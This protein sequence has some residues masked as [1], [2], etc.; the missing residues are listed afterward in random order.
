[1][2]CHQEPLF[3]LIDTLSI[4]GLHRTGHLAVLESEGVDLLWSPEFIGLNKIF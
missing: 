4:S 2:K 1:M 3:S